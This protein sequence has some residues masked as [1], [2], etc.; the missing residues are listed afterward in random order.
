M[1]R[2]LFAVMVLAVVAVAA[3]PAR[4]NGVVDPQIILRDGVRGNTVFLSQGLTTTIVFD[5]D[6][7]CSRFTGDIGGSPVPAM[8]CG[9]V[10]DTP[11]SISSLTWIISPPQLPLTFQSFGFNGLF[12]LSLDNTTLTFTFA[13]P[14][15]ANE[16]FHVEFL[17]FSTGTPISFVA[18]IPEPASLGLLVA[19]LGGL[20]LLRR[21]RAGAAN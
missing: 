7:R 14:L 18:A 5:T 4:A 2:R 1:Q 6:P 9:V 12:T 21:R 20:G 3:Q 15:E 17:N 16:D 19:G 10:N 13:T 8:D 11:N